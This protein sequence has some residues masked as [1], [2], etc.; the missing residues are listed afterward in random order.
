M[1]KPKIQTKFIEMFTDTMTKTR[2]YFIH[3]F[4]AI[5]CSVRANDV[6]LVVVA[7]MPNVATR[8][9]SRL[10]ILRFSV[11]IVE[12]WLPNPRDTI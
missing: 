3:T 6:L 9:V 4:V 5:R 7:M 8:I 10:I 12:M 2:K 1:A 11:L